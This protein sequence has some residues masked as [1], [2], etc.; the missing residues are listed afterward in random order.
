MSV[1]DEV[2]NQPPPFG[3]LNLYATDPLLQRAVKAWNAERAERRLHEFGALCGSHEVLEH[4][5]Q[6]NLH[7]PVLHTHDRSGHRVD[8]NEFHPSWHELMRIAISHGTHA[9]PWTDPGPGAHVARCAMSYLRTQVDEGHGCP[10]TMTFAV[11]PAL[12]NAP[13]VYE[14]W[15]PKILSYEY[16]PTDQP[17][18]RKRGALCGMGMTERQG[19][20]DV[21]ANT[22]RAVAIEGDRYRLDGHKWF[23]SAP[24]SDAFL[25]LAQ[26]PGGLSC[27]LLPRRLDDGRLNGLRLQRLKDKI[28][29]RSNASSEVEFHGAEAVRIGDEGRGVATIIE[30][31]HHTRLDCCVGS[32]ATLRRAVAE[33]VHHARHREAFGARLAEQP[34]MQQVLADLCLES[35]AATLLAMRIA[36][37]FDRRGDDAREQALSRILTAVGK[38]W[39]CRRAITGAAEALECTGGNGMV[40]PS[41]L[42]RM[43]VDA[44]V[45][46]IWE[47]SG[48]IQCL[49]VLRAAAREPESAEALLDLLGERRGD[50]PAYDGV[51]DRVAGAFSGDGPRPD[52]ARSLTEN[53]ALL[54]Q[55]GLVMQHA[56]APL[57]EAFCDARLAAGRGLNFGALGPGAPCADLIEAVVPAPG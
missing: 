7:P 19:G 49:D 44:P 54:A 39:I 23:F 27:F 47:G 12:R 13:G 10:V 34:L 11:I 1:H 55:A 3:G 28:G 4:G 22:T 45:N 40:Q 50:H 37:A 8:R 51:L 35:A 15:A 9:S 41:P 24:Q 42:A 46:S 5:V 56:P 26:A 18:D 33:A 38:Y 32:A 25:V 52:I 30:M 57:A 31:V 36:A 48:N 2:L 53:L 29:N 21:R 17:V 20:S 16:D 6:A 43:Y 14:R